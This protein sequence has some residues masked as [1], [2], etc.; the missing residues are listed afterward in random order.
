MADLVA[1]RL[2]QHAI[3]SKLARITEL[4]DADGHRIV[5]G[6]RL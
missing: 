5:S 2:Q 4:L 3:E 1:P 6:R